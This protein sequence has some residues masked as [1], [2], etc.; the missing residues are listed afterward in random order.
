LSVTRG[1][2]GPSSSLE[3]PWPG[4]RSRAVPGG[5]QKGQSG[6][7]GGRPGDVAEVRDLARRYTPE[8][9]DALQTIMNEQQASARVA[10]VEAL[11][12]RG[13]GRPTQPIAGDGHAEPVQLLVSW[14]RVAHVHPPCA[15]LKHQGSAGFALRAHDIWLANN[16]ARDCKVKCIGSGHRPAVVFG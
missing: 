13:W 9:I 16:V 7:P 4:F 5:F 10:A 1:W 6:N 11:L 14:A 3:L 2:V 8:A 12:N 15:G